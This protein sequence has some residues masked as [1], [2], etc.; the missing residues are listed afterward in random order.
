MF[1][2]AATGGAAWPKN[3]Y[4]ITTHVVVPQSYVYS[5]HHSNVS[6]GN[7]TGALVSVV[8]MA[9]L[10]ALSEGNGGAPVVAGHLTQFL[11][12]RCSY[13]SVP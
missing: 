4:C 9:R 7:P 11:G 5:L 13:P 3:L 12:Y 8:T 6:T 10:M 2:G 1:G